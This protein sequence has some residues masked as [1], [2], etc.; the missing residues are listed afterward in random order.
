M[1]EIKIRVIEPSDSKKIKNIIEAVMPEFEADC[2]GFA[3]HDPEVQ[4]MYQYY[5]K[6][7]WHYYVVE[8]SNQVVGGAG[9]APLIA[10]PKEYCELKKMYFLSMARGLGIG[11]QLLERCLEEARKLG[12]TYMYLE[13]LERMEQANS[14][15][16]KNGFNK[17]DGPMGNTGHHG[18]DA[19]Y[20]KKL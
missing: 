5:Q 8:K 9:I 13:T 1:P 14:L 12:F 6:E 7:N 17:L 20:R 18:C 15:Y 11:Q 4:D 16:K 10:G 19:W 2:D 3:I